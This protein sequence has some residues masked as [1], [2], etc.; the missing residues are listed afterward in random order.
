MRSARL[1]KLKR[2]PFVTAI[3]V[4]INVLIFTIGHFVNDNDIKMNGYLS[5]EKFW[6]LK[7]YWRML[8]SMFLHADIFHIF[9]NMLVVTFLGS[10]LEEYMGHLWYGIGYIVSGIG[11]NALS[12][13]LRYMHH[14]DFNSLGASGA[15]FGLDG[16]LLAIIMMGGMKRNN[17]SIERAIFSIG[18]SVY[19]GYTS[20]NIDNGAHIGGLITGY[21]IGLLF[22]TIYKKKRGRYFD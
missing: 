17:F 3:I 20:G 15:A 6:F 13:Y 4:G 2:F 12:L 9:N 5:L 7:E 11:G 21:A 18:L 8:T 14:E 1:F 19:A 10:M 22:C 16:L